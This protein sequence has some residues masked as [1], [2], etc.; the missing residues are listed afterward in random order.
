MLLDTLVSRALKHAEEAYF[1]VIQSDAEKEVKEA[2]DVALNFLQTQKNALK[3][4]FVQDYSCFF[5][6]EKR[7]S[8]DGSNQ[9]TL[10]LALVDDD[11]LDE[12]I[13][14]GE[15]SSK[16]HEEYEQFI[17]AIK[18]GV[19]RLGKQM[20]S[21]PDPD[22]LTPKEL[23]LLLH[24]VLEETELKFDHKKAIYSCFAGEAMQGLGPIYKGALDLLQQHDIITEKENPANKG[25]KPRYQFQS[26]GNNNNAAPQEPKPEDSAQ[27]DSGMTTPSINFNDLNEQVPAINNN[28]TTSGGHVP[29]AAINPVAANALNST[30]FNDSELSKTLYN[31]LS[32][33]TLNQ[34]F[35]EPLE[36]GAAVTPMQT[37]ELVG[38][39]SNLQSLNTDAL[40]QASLNNAHAIS[41]EVNRTVHEKLKEA[42]KNLTG[43]EANVIELVNQLFGAILEDPDLSDPVKVELGRLQIPYIKVA[44]LDVTMLKETTHPARLLLNELALYG[45]GLND[46]HD[47]A[48]ELIASITEDILDKFESNLDIFNTCLERLRE[49]IT[50]EKDDK[51]L[52]E[53]ETRNKA[54]VQSKLLHVKKVVIQQIR[55]FLKG[56]TFPK[57][58]HILVL[59]GFAPLFLKIWRR[60]G[61]DSENWQNTV[62]LFR[63]IVESVQPRESLQQLGIIVER[64]AEITQKANEALSEVTQRLSDDIDLLSGLEEIYQEKTIEYEQ[65]KKLQDTAPEEVVLEEDVVDPFDYSSDSDDVFDTDLS[66]QP[67]P[68]EI[69]AEL[70][71]EIK[72]GTWCEVYLG[73][74]K[75][76]RRLKVSSIVEDTAQI[77]FI[78]RSGKEAEIKDIDDFIDELDCERSRVIQDDQLF[79]KALTAVITNMQL[80]RAAT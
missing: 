43:P 42:A 38:L 62:D 80:M 4:Q 61:E 24:H 29:A 63:Q 56:K 16:V 51:Q 39:L 65:L 76:A 21:N 15:L 60:D 34:Q 67:T 66:N 37:D 30:L 70:P 18:R 55:Q 32:S 26:I 71:D 69:A 22:A 40:A 5:E 46:R 53:K 44:L 75:L 1:D 54:V 8:E 12:M 10:S 27:A 23:C 77:I 58:L 6:G 33:S 72:P 28:A 57:E 9:H 48:F 13:L 73:R 36:P 20:L 68:Q 79:D 64:S 14:I 41:D 74:D 2:A 17:K 19:V 11:T 3:T 45:I 31:F 50:S 49:T 52:A 59:R 25:Y 47:P 7:K 78:D 35:T